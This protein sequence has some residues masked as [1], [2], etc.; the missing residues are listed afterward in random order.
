M[1]IKLAFVLQLPS[2]FGK[3]VYGDF[4]RVREQLLYIYTDERGF[5]RK[6]FVH[7]LLSSALEKSARTV[8]PVR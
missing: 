6:F 8:P 3:P 5:E 1:S 2:M 4:G 7:L